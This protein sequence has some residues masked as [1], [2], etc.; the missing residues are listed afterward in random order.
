MSDSV[1]I[2][3]KLTPEMIEAILSQ[4]FQYVPEQNHLALDRQDIHSRSTT[5]V[6]EDL[7]HFNEQVV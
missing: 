5:Q 1:L 4:N 7:Q 6:L 3:Q 2:K